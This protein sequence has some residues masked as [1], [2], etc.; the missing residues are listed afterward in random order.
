MAGKWQGRDYIPDP[1]LYKCSCGKYQ[2]A[3]RSVTAHRNLRKKTH[4]ECAG[5]PIKIAETGGQ[6]PKQKG[7]LK[8]A[9]NWL[10]G[11]DQPLGT[12]LVAE[13]ETPPAGEPPPRSPKLP[14][15]APDLSNPE[16]DPFSEFEEREAPT[17]EPSW[18]R[19]KIANGHREPPPPRDNGGEGPAAE[20][21]PPD[22]EQTAVTKATLQ[23]VSIQVTPVLLTL[24]DALREYEGLSEPLDVWVERTTLLFW[25]ERGYEVTVQVSA[26]NGQAPK[27]VAEAMS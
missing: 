2:G 17:P 19:T 7:L 24:W 16:S 14:N 27:P 5:E 20:A 10:N 18:V 11:A 13:V 15:A 23:K 6:R 12:T 4:P 26:P 8:R 1:G 21:E 22:G 25:A 3:L 9:A